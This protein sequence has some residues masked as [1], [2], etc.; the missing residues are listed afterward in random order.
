MISTVRLDRIRRPAVAVALVLGIS[1]CWRYS[2]AEAG[3]GRGAARRG[4]LEAEVRSDFS[5]IRI[6]R[7]GDVRSLVFVRDSGEEVAE[8]RLDLK[9]PHRLIVPYTQFMFASYLVNPKQQRVLMVGLGGGA[10]V[11]FLRHHDPKV[12]IDAVEID[13]AVVKIAAEYFGTRSQ[14]KVKITTGDAFGY[15]KDTP[16]RYD[17]IYMD[18]FLKP[19][20]DTDDTGVPLRM[21]TVRFYEGI[22]KK[23]KPEGVVVFNLNRH[24]GTGE[25]I[26][27]IRIAFR[28]V[29]VFRVSRLCVVVVGSVAET[30]EKASVL[31]TR[32]KD[33]DGRFKANFSFEKMVRNL[34]R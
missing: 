1:L 7:T 9:T 24:K 31:S 13:P 22:Q 10:M 3:Y 25:D 33:L 32:A 30:R 19:S 8:T 28:Q 16:G 23:L 12:R 11:H 5:L 18:A 21:K 15:L 4:L 14:G 6:R 27:T 34:V 2:T 17:A 29:Y 26:Q 20:A